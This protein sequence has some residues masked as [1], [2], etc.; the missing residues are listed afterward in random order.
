MGVLEDGLMASLKE[1]Y[2]SQEDRKKTEKSEW[3]KEIKDLL[4]KNETL[5]KF[6]EINHIKGE[7]IKECTNRTRG[8]DSVRKG[9]SGKVLFSTP[10]D[11]ALNWAD[12]SK[13]HNY[14]RDVNEKYREYV[15][16]NKE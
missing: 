4:S 11:V 13:R 3:K 14:W 5:T 16:N 12:T 6:L 10:I 9:I 2:M 15:D 7:F 1:Q 8:K